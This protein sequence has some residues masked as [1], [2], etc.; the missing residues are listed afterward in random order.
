MSEREGSG[1][2]RLGEMLVER[3]MM[4]PAAIYEAIREQIESIV[5]SLFA[6]E[7]GEVTFRIGESLPAD[8]VR[9]LVPMRQVIVQGI[10]RAA[11]AKT[12]VARLGRREA[13][14]EPC[15][16][17]EDLIEIA[18]DDNEYKLLCMVNGKRTLFELCTHG[19]HSPADN[20]KL[21]YAYH[22]LQIIKKGPAEETPG[23]SRSS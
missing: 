21:L 20:G 14:F 15:Y 2:R 9:I 8:T 22:V 6:W 10:K 17:V 4:S 19:P 13:V 16:R 3:E 7:E 1:P 5:W 12:A 11:N 18:L 23:S